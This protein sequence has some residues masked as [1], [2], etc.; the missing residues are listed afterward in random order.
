MVRGTREGGEIPS[1]FFIRVMEKNKRLFTEKRRER[2]EVLFE[3]WNCKTEEEKQEA[4]LWIP[5]R[6]FKKCFRVKTVEELAKFLGD[7]KIYFEK[8]R[9]LSRLYIHCPKFQN[10]SQEDGEKFFTRKARR[11]KIAR[12]RCEVTVNGRQF[13]SIQAACAY[14]GWGH[15]KITREI[16]KHNGGNLQLQIRDTARQWDRLKRK[17]EI[18]EKYG[19]TSSFASRWILLENGDHPAVSKK[20]HKKRIFYYKGA[21]YYPREGVSLDEFITAIKKLNHKRWITWLELQRL[22]AELGRSEKIRPFLEEYP[23]AVHPVLKNVFLRKKVEKYF[24]RHPSASKAKPKFYVDGI[25]FYFAWERDEYLH[26]K[27]RK[28][29]DKEG[30]CFESAKFYEKLFEK[31][32]FLVLSYKDRKMTF[33]KLPE[34]HSA[35]DLK[36]LFDSIHKRYWVHVGD[37]ADY[38]IADVL[39]IRGVSH[40]YIQ[41]FKSKKRTNC[42]FTGYSEWDKFLD[43]I[44]YCSL[45]KYATFRAEELIGLLSPMGQRKIRH[46]YEEWTNGIKY[47]GNPMVLKAK[48]VLWRFA[49]DFFQE[50]LKK[51][52]RVVTAFGREVKIYPVEFLREMTDEIIQN[53]KEWSRSKRFSKLPYKDEIWHKSTIPEKIVDGFEF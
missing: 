43:E 8:K 26:I 32:G 25:P 15:G 46:A 35:Q 9:I 51:N 50:E 21:Y 5:F 11:D 12:K 13:S 36:K 7:N 3:R 49:K 39:R 23:E 30:E 19:V 33:K 2:I 10:S 18:M 47:P 27:E 4:L 20:W 31:D 14:T 53:G 6:R 48:N 45:G 37:V 28:N 40:P 17:Q 41:E 24:R 52:R 1:P 42:E 44:G 38:N 22:N 34:K 29:A 16:K